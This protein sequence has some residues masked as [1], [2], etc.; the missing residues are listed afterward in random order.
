MEDLDYVNIRSQLNERRTRLSDAIEK[1]NQPQHLVS[2]LQ[3]VDSALEKID[4][5]TYGIC[6]ACHEEI[7]KEWLEADPLANFCLAH[8][9]E[10]EQR[11]LE[12]DLSLAAKIQSSLLPKNNFKSFGYE[13]SFHYQPAGPV[14]GDYC[15]IMINENDESILFIIGDITGKGIAAS[16]LMT[17]LHAFVHSM[18]GLNLR[19]NELIERVNRLFCES[20]LYSH[21]VTM[22]CGRSYKNGLVE[23]CNAGHCLPVLIKKNEIINL[24]SN[25]MPVGLFQTGTY[26]SNQLKLEKDETILLYT[27][28]LSEANFG[29]EE[30][31]ADRINI[32][33]S[34]NFG[35]CPNDLINTFL[36]DISSFTKNSQ[37]RDDLTML[38][39]RRS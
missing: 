28:G 3:K 23:I 36:S 6:E 13:I 27:D 39:I 12:Q 34:K 7:E 15:D 26:F 24:D 9:S 14:S 25:G 17:Q 18:A 30:Y 31:G 29:A 4:N 32:V 21:F 20:S 38:A 35:K 8:L 37:L 5:R 11:L 10:K 33:A 1:S 22:I 2:L 16:M 19:A